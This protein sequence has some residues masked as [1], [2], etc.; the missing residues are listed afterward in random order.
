MTTPSAA[1]S[2]RFFIEA[3]RDGAVWTVR[4]VDGFPAPMNADGERSVPF[5]S[6]RSSAE[7]IRDTSPEYHSFEVIS[8]R[9]DDFRTNW[10]PGLSRDGLKVGVNWAGPHATGYEL[11]PEEVEAR[12]DAIRAPGGHQ[13]PIR[14]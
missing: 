5:W 8:I 11:S 6:R 9:L 2:V 10:L 14:R 1:N 12:F 3:I 4:D 13:D 7:R